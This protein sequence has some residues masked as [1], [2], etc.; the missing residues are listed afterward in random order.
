MFMDPRADA[1]ADE[2]VVARA[3]AGE[4]PLF[5]ILMRRHNQ[6]LYRVVR[7][8]LREE[9]DCED[10]V[11]ATFV[12]AYTHLEQF[13]GQARFSTWLT[14]IALNEALA[15]VRQR[16]RRAEVALDGQ[17]EDMSAVVLDTQG[18]EEEAAR[19]ELG[20]LL[21]RAIDE[22]PESYRVVIMRREVQ[23]LP[24]AEIAECL[25]LS[26]EAVKMRVH[27]GKAML[28]ETMAARMDAAAASAFAFLGAR[29]D[30]IVAGV[31]ARLAE[32]DARD[33]KRDSR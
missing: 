15:R 22:L 33:P 31:L 27:R 7:A 24:I 6:R 20:R 32:L 28:R 19:R 17:G 1:L 10:A 5:E 18:P 12:A 29:C 3:R 21:E 26:E 25:E 13:H 14:R 16:T 4:R 23:Q 2:D 30:R 8:I 9:A 11:Q